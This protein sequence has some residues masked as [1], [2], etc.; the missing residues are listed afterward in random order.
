MIAFSITNFSE[1]VLTGLILSCVA[2]VIW[3]AKDG[4]LSR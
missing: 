2:I 3:I 4:G 1:G